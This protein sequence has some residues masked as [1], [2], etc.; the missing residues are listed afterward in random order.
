MRGG[1]QFLFFSCDGF[2]EGGDG[3]R[4]VQQGDHGGVA[5][6]TGGRGR[7]DVHNG[8]VPAHSL[9]YT[10]HQNLQSCN[11][12]F[13]LC[14]YVDFSFIFSSFELSKFIIFEIIKTVRV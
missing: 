14:M 4:Q 3:A 9:T 11:L 7:G 5:W 12:P 2:P 8:L 10:E 13:L 6:Q 1:D